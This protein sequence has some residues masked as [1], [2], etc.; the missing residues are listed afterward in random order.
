M[1]HWFA[2][3]FSVIALTA[4]VAAADPIEG[5]W[6]TEDGPVAAIVACGDSFCIRG[7]GKN[8]DKEAGRMAAKG[9]GT[10]VG[11]ITRPKDGKTYSGKAALS[12]NSL[13]V[14]GCILGGLV[15]ESQ[16]WHRK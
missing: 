9:D 6:Q 16:T 12:G 11:T 7:T 8:A 3:A 4:S 5:R 2:I 1:I 15:C 10:Y 13:E 14:S